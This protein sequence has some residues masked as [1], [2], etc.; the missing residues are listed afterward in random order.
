MPEVIEN[1]AID[2]SGTVY[3]VGQSSGS[4]YTI[5]LSTGTASFVGNPATGNST[6]IGLAYSGGSLWELGYNGGD[7]N[8]PLWQ[9]DPTSASSTL[10]GP[11]GLEFQPDAMTVAS[12]GRRRWRSRRD[13]RD[14]LVHPQPGRKR[15]R[16]PGDPQRQ[17]CNRLALRRERQPTGPQL[18]RRH[19]LHSGH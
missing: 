1:A 7:P 11:N 8:T 18:P 13:G 15:H 10:I 14:L 12:W 9:I 19:Q 4:I 5:D 2:S 16:R 3:G 17:E 6:L